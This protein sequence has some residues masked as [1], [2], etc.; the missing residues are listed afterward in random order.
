MFVYSSLHRCDLT[1]NKSTSASYSDSNRLTEAGF[2]FPVCSPLQCSMSLPCRQ[3]ASWSI[4]CQTTKTHTPSTHTCSRQHTQQRAAKACSL[5][6][7][8]TDSHLRRKSWQLVFLISSSSS[9][10]FSQLIV[11]G[12]G[13]TD[14]PSKE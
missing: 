11:E 9:P 8:Q 4:S 7:L 2:R 6:R 5:C 14:I 10:F 12:S 1:G 3:N 13:F